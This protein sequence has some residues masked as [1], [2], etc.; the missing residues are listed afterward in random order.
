MDYKDLTCS[1]IACIEQNIKN[2]LE[3]RTIERTV[4][5]SYHRIREVF[6]KHTQI[7][8][9]R[10]ILSRRI[11][12]AAFDIRHTKKS[13]TAIALEY[14]F[15]NLDTFTRAFHRNTGLT[16]SEFKKS[17]YTCGRKIICP[18][19]YAP[20]ILNLDNPRFTLPK[21]REVNEM[22]EM[23][24]TTD[25]CILYGVPKVYYGR[26][27]DGHNQRT[28]FPMC[29]Q[30]VLNY[31]GQNIDYTYLM[32]ATGAAFRQRWDAN[33]WNYAAVDIRFTYD[34]PLEPFERGYIGAGRKFNIHVKSDNIKAIDKE[35]ALALIKSELD[36]GRPLIGLGVVGPPEACVIT[37]YK[38]NGETLLGWS[39]FQHDP[40]F[41]GNVE[42][43]ETGLVGGD[44]AAACSPMQP[45]YFCGGLSR[46]FSPQ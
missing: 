6:Q 2:K 29:L 23:K 4:G 5:F 35:A 32:A 3:Y 19:V 18:G 30:A 21:L 24:K 22:G 37:G 9:S 27:V 40:H 8:L 46:T 28:P 1:P 12:N 38:N 26:E 11:A 33:G 39:L 7:S 10:Y 13:I 45:G 25:S 44:E 42:F 14:E 31:M 43:D 16:P 34:R 36:C 17:D 41:G 15:S 20:V